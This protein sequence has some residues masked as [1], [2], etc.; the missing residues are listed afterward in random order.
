[1]HSHG[2]ELMSIIKDSLSSTTGLS[3]HSKRQVLS[4]VSSGS[5]ELPSISVDPPEQPLFHKRPLFPKH[6]IRTLSVNEQKQERA[7]YI[8][9]APCRKRRRG[10]EEATECQELVLY[11][12]GCSVI[13]SSFV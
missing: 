12:V 1:M 6:V 11:T 9:D 4:G 7:G 8:N 13:R 10:N 2:Q 3:F 5:Q